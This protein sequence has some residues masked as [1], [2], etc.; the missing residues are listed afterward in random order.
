MP[1]ILRMIEKANSDH[2]SIDRPGVI[3][4][5]GALSP[6]FAI[7][8]AIAVHNLALTALL[9]RCLQPH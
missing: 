6:D 5:G 9:L 7:A 8:L 2:L 1:R 3:H 4:P